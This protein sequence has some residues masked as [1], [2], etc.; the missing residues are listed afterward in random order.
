[1][2]TKDKDG[3]GVIVLVILVVI[4]LGVLALSMGG[5]E[6]TIGDRIGNAANEITEGVEEAGEELDPDRTLGEEFGDAVEDTGERM[7][8]VAE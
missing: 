8:D 7:Q 6:E 4:V 3:K 1:M 2:A 5:R